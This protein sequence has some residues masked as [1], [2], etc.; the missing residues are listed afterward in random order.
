MWK[1]A[2]LEFTNL[3]FGSI[4]ATVLKFINIFDHGKTN[5]ISQ[6]QTIVNSFNRCFSKLKQMSMI[7]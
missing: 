5:M 4:I 3:Y 1:S 2:D 7:I 6:S